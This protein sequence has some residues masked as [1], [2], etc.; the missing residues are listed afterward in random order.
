MQNDEI[1]FGSADLR[2]PDDLRRPLREHIAQLRERYLRRGWGGRVEFGQRPA[3]IVIDLA[4]YWT[5]ST[6]QVGSNVE[7]VVA[8]A[9]RVLAAARAA[10]APC[11]LQRMPSI[12]PIH[13]A[14]K[15]GNCDSL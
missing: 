9:C 11:F 10:K 15:T 13:P 2:L 7:S 8:G 12:C 5:Q 14:R 3:L 1:P 6:T 4:K